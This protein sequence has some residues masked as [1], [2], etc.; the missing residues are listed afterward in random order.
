MRVHLESAEGALNCQS[1]KDVTVVANVPWCL[2]GLKIFI[3]D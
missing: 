1:T 3:V 2:H